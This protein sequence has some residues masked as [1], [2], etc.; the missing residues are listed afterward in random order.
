MTRIALTDEF[1]LRIHEDPQCRK[2]DG[3]DIGKSRHGRRNAEI[4]PLIVA[5]GSAFRMLTA[6]RILLGA[7]RHKR[8]ANITNLFNIYSGLIKIYI[9]LIN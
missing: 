2:R 7:L 8:V 4:G 9:M 6:M 3:N 5:A 1:I